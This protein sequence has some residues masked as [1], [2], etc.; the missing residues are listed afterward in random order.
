MYAA[1]NLKAAQSAFKK[2][3][4]TW[5][6]Y[7]GAIAVWSQN[8]GHI[9]QLFDYGSAVRKIMYTTNAIESI[10]SS[11]R[12]VV[13]KGAFPNENAVLRALFLRTKELLNKWHERP[14]PNWSMVRNQ[15]FINDDIA[16]RI[17]QYDTQI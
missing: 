9:E 12:K 3:K 6:M 4:I 7:P 11:Y 2:I 8:F 16:K 17:S 5:S 14:I 15:L 1:P 13:K 10:H